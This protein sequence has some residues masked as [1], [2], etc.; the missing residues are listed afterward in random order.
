MRLIQNVTEKFIGRRNRT[1]LMYINFKLYDDT[2]KAFIVGRTEN[3]EKIVYF[4]YPLL[5]TLNETRVPTEIKLQSVEI[6]FDDN[7]T[8]LLKYEHNSREIV[9]PLEAYSVG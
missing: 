3:N 5:V 4:L 6:L 1:K 8:I 2:I 7:E 9:L